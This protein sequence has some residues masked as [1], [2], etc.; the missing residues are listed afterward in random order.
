[1]EGLHLIACG[2]SLRG[3]AAKLSIAGDGCESGPCLR[4]WSRIFCSFQTSQM[5]LIARDTKRKSIT[6]SVECLNATA[7]KRKSPAS[8]SIRSRTKGLEGRCGCDGRFICLVRFRKST[9]RRH[10]FLQI[11]NSGVDSTKVPLFQ[12]NTY[13]FPWVRLP[14]KM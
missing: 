9:A 12:T 2:T 8:M 11:E 3:N 1:M 4:G 13:I 14:G 10:N 7:Q 6:Q 5:K